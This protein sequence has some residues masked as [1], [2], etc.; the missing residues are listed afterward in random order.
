VVL[1]DLYGWKNYPFGLFL[2]GFRGERLILI[3]FWAQATGVAISK[4]I[5]K[6]IGRLRGGKFHR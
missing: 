1:H 5:S 3:E 4:R 2:L 6:S